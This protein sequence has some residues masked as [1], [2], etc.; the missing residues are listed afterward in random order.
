MHVCVCVYVCVC[1]HVH[2]ICSN[3]TLLQVTILKQLMNDKNAVK[4]QYSKILFIGPPGVGKTLTRLRLCNEMEN[5]ISRGST[6]LPE[7]TLLANFNQVLIYINSRDGQNTWITSNN[8]Q[9]EAQ[10]LFRYMC[11][12]DPKSYMMESVNETNPSNDQNVDVGD[13]PVVPMHQSVQRRFSKLMRAILQLR[14]RRMPPHIST[15]ADEPNDESLQEPSAQST[16]SETDDI[17]SRLQDLVRNFN[18]SRFSELY[19]SSILVNIH[20]IGG[21]PGFLEMIPSLI[22]GPA[23]YLVFLNLSLP[24]DE[25]YEIPFSRQSDSIIP[26]ESIYTVKSTISQ[27]LTAISSINPLASPEQISTEFEHF[28]WKK[29]VA[30]V[31]GTHQDKLEDGN[32]PIANLLKQKHLEVRNIIDNFCESGVV[33]TPAREESFVAIDNYKGTEESD[34][35]VLRA[36]VMDLITKKLNVSIPIRPA[37]LIL[38]IILRKEFEVVSLSTCFEIGNCLNMDQE[39]TKTALW[40]LHNI[41]GAIMYYPEIEDEDGWFKTHIICSPQVIFDS[42][43]QVIVHSL[44]M[45]HSN[46]RVPACE[47]LRRD[48]IEKGLFSIEAIREV[49]ETNEITRYLPIEKLIKLLAHVNLLS[50]IKLHNPQPC[51][52]SIQLFMP[53]ILECASEKELSNPPVT[54]ENHPAPIFLK[55]KF[56]YIPTGVFCCLV[57]R[58]VTKGAEKIFGELWELKKDN[59]KRNFISFYLSELHYVSLIS[60]DTCYEIRVERRGTTI[61]LHDLCSQVLTT[62]LYLLKEA[63]QHLEPIIAFECACDK[64]VADDR[65]K[66]LCEVSNVAICK[67]R[68]ERHEVQLR[69]DQKVWMGKASIFS[70]IIKLLLMF[71]CFLAQSTTLSAETEM[72]LLSSLPEKVTVH[73]IK[74]EEEL[75]VSHH[76]HIQSVTNSHFGAYKV[77]IKQEEKEILSITRILFKQGTTYYLF[78]N[79]NFF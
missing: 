19:E 13:Q 67:G 35:F 79:I 44:Q 31:V 74:D 41:V 66:H 47:S 25:R 38:S 78:I 57:T 65:L 71:V 11:M 45:L 29:P 37:W 55:F 60:H 46:S 56:G 23:A 62:I 51:T 53:A 39:E 24:L 33:V 69:D 6:P 1:L 14:H 59:V 76:L 54:D 40:Y 48:W 68:D 36:H 21:Q 12:L 42:I 58:I 4:V 43:S 32:A 18:S 28:K 3:I 75:C 8:S 73:W 16:D 15:V 20:D 72:R 34:L 52:P 22:S 5:M 63:Y 26:F 30:T 50:E 27:I 77:D 9:E 64:Y 49:T 70:F 7:S 17:L 61:S 10:I 2:S